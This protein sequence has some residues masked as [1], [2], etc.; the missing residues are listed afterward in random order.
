MSCLSHRVNESNKICP[1]QLASY[2]S[3]LPLV[4]CEIII[5]AYIFPFCTYCLLLFFHISIISSRS[6][7]DVI[8]VLVIIVCRQHDIHYHSSQI[9]LSHIIIDIFNDVVGVRT[10]IYCMMFLFICIHDVYII[11]F[12]VM[13]ASLL[14]FLSKKFVFLCFVFFKFPVERFNV[15]IEIIICFVTFPSFGN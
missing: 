14:C 3:L 10:I 9:I 12:P 7:V 6:I 5:N 4:K 11:M 13:L 1:W 8:N 15:L 2:V